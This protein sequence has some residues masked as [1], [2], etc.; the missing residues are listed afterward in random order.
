MAPAFPAA[1]RVAKKLGIGGEKVWEWHA[2]DHCDPD[3]DIMALTHSR[4]EWA[5][6]NTLDVMEDGNILLT[7][8]SSP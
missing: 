3:I 1:E 8:F 6:E 2:N 5:H 4:Q 7:S